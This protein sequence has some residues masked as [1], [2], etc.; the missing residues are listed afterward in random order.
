MNATTVL[1]R[2][3]LQGDRAQLPLQRRSLTIE[4]AETLDAEAR[5][6]ELAFSSEEPYARWWGDEILDHESQ[7]VRLGRL[8][9]GGA[10]LVNHD[11][12]DQVGVV[13]KAWIGGDRKGR[14]VVRFGK[15][16][17]AAEIFQDV[18]DGIR[19]LVSVGYWIHGMQLESSVGDVDT[20]RVNDWEPLEVSIV[21]VPADPSV[22]VGRAIDD[23]P[24]GQRTREVRITQP[25]REAMDNTETQQ[26]APASTPAA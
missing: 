15:S 19:K 7:S 21:A 6:V 23:D 16:A 4:R 26:G 22:G 9:G 2:K 17:R 5:T 25:K 20:Y 18:Q 14:A 24:Q 11:T 13:E 12:D 8:N 1:E 3:R 10:V